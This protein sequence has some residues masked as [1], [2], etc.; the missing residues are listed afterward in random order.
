MKLS[1]TQTRAASYLGLVSQ[2]IAINLVP[3]LFI[4]FQSDYGLSYEQLGRL[5][6]VNFGIQICVDLIMVKFGN[7]ISL[8]FQALTAQFLTVFGLLLLS[9]LPQLMENKLAALVIC[10]F[11]LAVGAGMIEVAVSPI[12]SLLPPSG[13]K[14][15]IPLLHSFYCIGH[16]FVCV[17]STLFLHFAGNASWGL[18]PVIWATVP[19]VGGI[20]FIKAPLVPQIPESERTPFSKLFSVKAFVI[21][22]I[23]MI[24]AGA[25]EQAI[26]QWTSL[27]AEK[28]LQMPKLVGDL[29]GLCGFAVM[30]TAGRMLFGL[31]GAKID[32]RKALLFSGILCS[33]SF[34]GITL[35]SNPI[36]SLVC[37]ALCGISVALMWPGILQLVSGMFPKGGVGMFSLFSV[38]GDIGCSLGPWLVGLISDRA[39][40]MGNVPSTGIFA[41]VELSAYALRVGILC[42]IAFP[43]LFSLLISFL[44]KRKEKQIG[45][46]SK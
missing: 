8:R 5:T 1:Y 18:L 38:M 46:S 7:R 19:A 3:L 37:C 30:M 29:V 2:A 42:A 27:F 16:I 41:G 36:V 11:F 44:Q 40:A 32:L 10:E 17:I 21:L 14:A 4:V 39:E 22:L 15:E 24:C 31:F 45:I 6:L 9:F 25:S 33:L 26:A 34:L 43:A 13:G 12:I 28:A 35:I 23:M 20:L